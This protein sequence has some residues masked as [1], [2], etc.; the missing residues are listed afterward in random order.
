MSSAIFFTLLSFSYANIR[1]TNVPSFLF[2][3]SRLSCPFSFF[4]SPHRTSSTLSLQAITATTTITFPSLFL[5][6]CLDEL[7]LPPAPPLPPPPPPSPSPT[8]PHF[9]HISYHQTNNVYG[10]PL[11]PWHPPTS[12]PPPSSIFTATD[13][14]NR[15]HHHYTTS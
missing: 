9:T 4:V 14:L 11:T 10:D 7:L 2:C 5:S 1:R 15:H 6:V 12:H 8:P 13:P 3:S